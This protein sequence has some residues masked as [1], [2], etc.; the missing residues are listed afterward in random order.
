M[1]LESHSQTE[2]VSETV[3]LPSWNPGASKR[4]LI[5]FVAR[6]SLHD[7]P[8]FVPIPERIAVFDNDGTLWAE[9]PLYMQLAFVIDQIIAMAPQHPEWHD[10]EPFKSVIKGDIKAALADG[11]SSAA[12]LLA[13]T[14]AGMSTEDFDKSARLWFQ[15]AQH[16]QLKRPYTEL[17]YQPMLELINFLRINGF[18]IFIASAGGAD[19]MRSVTEKLYGIPPEQVIGTTGKTRYEF[20]DGKPELIKLAEVDNFDEGPGKPASIHK[21]IGR[22]PLLAFGNSDG[23]YEMLEWVTSQ[24]RPHLGLLL[25]HTDA[26]REW[27]YDRG[28]HVGKLNRALDAASR[29]RWI[30][31]DMKKDWKRVYPFH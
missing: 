16:P 1:E 23:D 3:I 19:F 11:K 31:V 24:D 25:H 15:R 28:S 27:S 2:K 13:V 17:I 12:A 6:V 30:L 7:S 21:F 22:R 10:K 14:H 9:K 29:A 18:K 5:D 4:A 8:E 26:E 20:H